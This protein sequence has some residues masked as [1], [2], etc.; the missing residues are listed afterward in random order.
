[1]SARGK[2]TLHRRSGILEV[3]TL[4]GRE[5]AVNILGEHA[6]GHPEE[7]L[8]VLGLTLAQAF[9]DGMHGIELEAHPDNGTVE[10]RYWGPTDAGAICSWD[11][12][13]PPAET[14]ASLI[15][16]IVSVCIFDSGLRPQ[17]IIHAKLNGELVNVRVEM[18]SWFKVRLTFERRARET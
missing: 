8:R 16:A 4:A 12:G 18:D 2:V 5:Y 11:M 3:R 1:M 15:K 7:F 9:G 14:Y 6:R 17:G 10:M 13:P